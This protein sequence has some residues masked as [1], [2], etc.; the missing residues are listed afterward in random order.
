MDTVSSRNDARV[1]FVSSL[2]GFPHTIGTD[3]RFRFSRP[4]RVGENVP[5]NSFP[6]AASSS[7]APSSPWIRIT[8]RR[9]IPSYASER[10]VAWLKIVSCGVRGDW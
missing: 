7:F 8:G 6:V 10:F 2:S 9:R 1:L 3:R 5:Q 4:G